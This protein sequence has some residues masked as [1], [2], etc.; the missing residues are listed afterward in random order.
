MEFIRDL[1]GDIVVL[2]P[3]PGA[4]ATGP[5]G[6]AA[7]GDLIKSLVGEGKTRFVLDLATVD[8]L[9]SRA[10]GAIIGILRLMQQKG[11]AFVLCEPGVDHF[12]TLALMKLT[13]IIPIRL[14]RAAATAAIDSLRAGTPA[15]EALVVGNPTLDQVVAHFE[16]KRAALLAA[17]KPTTDSVPPTNRLGAD[18]PS[19]SGPAPA[20]TPIPATTRPAPPPAN[21]PADDWELLLRFY[22]ATSD[23]CQRNDIPF[24][25]E[26]PFA[27]VFSRLAEKLAGNPPPPTTSR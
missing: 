25:T 10:I 6:L 19:R 22:S 7:V 17:R 8:L 27:T 12:R 16:R 23:L 26:T 21:N 13:R 24:N 14:D 1:V 9:E 20:T 18:A 15:G 11:G 4:E 2:S 5:D 3:K